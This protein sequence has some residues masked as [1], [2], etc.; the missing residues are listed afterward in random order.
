MK[1]RRRIKRY[2][3]RIKKYLLRITILSMQPR[4]MFKYCN[5][6]REA[7]EWEARAGRYILTVFK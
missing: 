3:Y 1:K 2:N 4:T 7:G 6:W 5:W